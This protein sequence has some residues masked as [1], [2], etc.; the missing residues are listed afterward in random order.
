[1]VS[2][3]IAIALIAA[4]T[5]AAADDFSKGL[6][7]VLEK[8]ACRS[9]HSPD[10][11]ASA[12]RLHFPE[13]DAPVNRIEAFGKS[14]VGLIDRDRPGQSLLLEKPT[15]RIAHTGGKRIEPGSPEEAVLRSWID[16][17]AKMTGPELAQAEQYRNAVHRA[18]AGKQNGPVLRRL[19]NAQ[20]NNTVRDLLGEQGVPASQFPPEDFVNGYKNQYQAQSLSPMLFEAYSTAAE[21]IA[22]N[23]FR[24]GDAER[25]IPCKPSVPCRAEF[26]RSFGLKAFR[27]PL[28]A[29]ER[30]RYEG[31]FA[32]SVDFSKGAQAVIEAMLQSPHFLFQLDETTDAAWKPYARASRLS[33]ALWNTTPDDGLLA[34]AAAGELN[35]PKGVEKIA[36]RMLADPKAKEALEEFV[37]Q[38]MRF[39]RVIGTG[40]DTR[41]Y[42]RFNRESAAAMTEETRRFIAD[43][44]WSDRDFM[45]V[46]T[47][48]NGYVNAELARIY[49]LPAPGGEFEKVAFP[50][51]SERAG[52]LGQASFLTLTSTPNDTSPTARGLFVREHFLCQHI[53]DPPPGVSTVLPPLDEAKP[54]TNRQ[55]LAVHTTDQ[56]CASCHNLID[57]IG[58][59]LE[60][61]DAIGGRREKAKLLFYPLDRKSK[62]PPKKVELDLDTSGWVAGIADSKF[63]S[64]RELGA[65]LARTPQCQECIVKQVFRYVAGRLETDADR[66]LIRKVY[67]D[68]RNSGFR[69]QELLVSLTAAREFPESGAIDVS[70]R[71]PSR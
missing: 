62:E 25:L 55:R 60:K 66:A 38:W 56:T 20:Y 68:F 69:F 41:V 3:F 63:S 57:P 5:A 46:F 59:G 58:F 23:A 18:A 44:V 11:V 10:G 16:R 70:Q 48:K 45:E 71:V 67:Q 53:A 14:L 28:D 43:L 49:E 33:Y 30:K 32:G 29:M 54:Q 36:R 7:A 47:A 61:F 39:D 24:R 34:S 6:Y 17:L 4:C 35:T 2:R 15:N 50:E 64:P 42:P 12:T 37:S 31:Y 13:A 9:C 51:A 1:V 52:L 8:A 22:R 26:I 40:R 27:R 21:K 19:T 65:I